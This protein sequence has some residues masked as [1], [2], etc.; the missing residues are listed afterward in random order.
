MAVAASMAASIGDILN[1]YFKILPVGGR[2]VF[3]KNGRSGVLHC[4]GV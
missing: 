1:W 3:S 4:E 2:Y